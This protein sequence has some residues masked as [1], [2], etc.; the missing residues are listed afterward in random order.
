MAEAAVSAGVGF[1]R[2]S[3]R[4]GL[5]AM[6]VPG[7]GRSNRACAVRLN[8]NRMRSTSAGFVAGSRATEGTGGATKLIEEGPEGTEGAEGEVCCVPAKDEVATLVDGT[9]AAGLFLL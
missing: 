2:M 5:P 7:A 1:A 8:S 9:A 3:V 6:R 4:M